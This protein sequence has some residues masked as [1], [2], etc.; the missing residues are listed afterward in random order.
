VAAGQRSGRPPSDD[1]LF[2]LAQVDALA[3]QKSLERL[4]SYGKYLLGTVSA[5]GTALTG[6]G[7]FS[8]AHDVQQNRLIL[9]PIG[10]ACF[11]LALASMGITPR[12]DRV[13]RANPDSVRDY[14]T[15]L[16]KNRGR[17]ITLAG[18]LFA[19]SLGSAAVVLLLE[20]GRPALF[21][22]KISLTWKRDDSKPELNLNVKFVDAPRTALVE[23]RILAMDPK[24]PG[25]TPIALFQ[26]FSRP[27]SDGNVE[28][29]G[30]I[31]ALA[32]YSSLVLVLKTTAGA[33]EL[34]FEQIEIPQPQLAAPRQSVALASIRFEF[35][36]A[37][38]HEADAPVLD[39][40]VPYLKAHPE[41][42]MRVYGYCDEKGSKDYNLRLSRRRAQ[43]VADYFDKR[44]VSESRVMIAG[45]GKTNFVADNE[46]DAGRA[47]NRRVDLLVPA[48][49]D[50]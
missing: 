33:R 6:F 17:Y 18:W 20:R 26:D 5:V 10:L 11:S 9:I 23:T 49:V 41:V 16:I 35:N 34:Y 37:T 24:T 40:V 1:E 19:L 12:V 32:T 43:A 48:G 13:D 39:R 47:L 22:P 4:D 3:P 2:W 45:L 7:I 14:Y 28:V 8:S 21:S 36:N 27:D 25:G 50:Y 42:V 31:T 15:K 30:R 38:I 29:S 46:T 44:G